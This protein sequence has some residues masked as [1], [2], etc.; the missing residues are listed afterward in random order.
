[1]H[2][3]AFPDGETWQ[4]S[5]IVDHELFDDLDFGIVAAE[6]PAVQTWKWRSEPLSML[7]QVMSVGYPYAL[8]LEHFIIGIRAFSGHVVSGPTFHRL[9]AT[10]RVYEPS[11]QCPRGLSGSPLLSADGRTDVVGIIIGNRSTQMLVFS[12][13]EVLREPTQETIVERYESLQLGI[14]L[15]SRA[16]LDTH[17]RILGRTLREH[18]REHN[19]VA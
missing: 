9:K 13:K 1:M 2:G 4:A 15:Q 17:C 6:L 3:I 10:L 11:F 7:H 16:V 19:L 5:R 12:D 8:D 18:L 14:A